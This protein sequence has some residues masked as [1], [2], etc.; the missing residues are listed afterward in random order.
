[1]TVFVVAE[2]TSTS[3][4]PHDNDN[5]ATT[6]AFAGDSATLRTVGELTT[7]CDRGRQAS[8]TTNNSTTAMTIDD[9][10]RPVL[11]PT[12]TMMCPTTRPSEVSVPLAASVN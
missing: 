5:T 8:D 7:T 3:T 11:Q 10:D 9:D 1:M 12:I 4:T 6:K 2:G